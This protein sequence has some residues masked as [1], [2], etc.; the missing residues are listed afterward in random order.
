MQQGGRP[1]TAESHL[2][3]CYLNGCTDDAANTILVAAGYNFR[4]ILASLKTLLR[5][6]LIVILRAFIIRSA[7]NPAY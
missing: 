6:I 1:V 2:G 5:R 3:R 7:P 4:R